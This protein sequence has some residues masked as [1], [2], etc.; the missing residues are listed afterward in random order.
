MPP[1]SCAGKAANTRAR[2]WMCRLKCV[3]FLKLDASTVSHLTLSHCTEVS[4][5]VWT[6]KRVSLRALS[7]GVSSFAAA[8]AKHLAQAAA[9]AAGAAAPI[10][11]IDDID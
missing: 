10:G 3:S 6:S 7:S 8:D 1:R 2:A 9:F 11:D 4:Y 5:V